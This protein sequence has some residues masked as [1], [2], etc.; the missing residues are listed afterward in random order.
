M[1]FNA[2]WASFNI[3]KKQNLRKDF[4]S[5]LLLFAYASVILN[6]LSHFKD[7][8]SFTM[9]FLLIVSI[10]FKPFLLRPGWLHG[11]LTFSG[12]QPHE[13]IGF[14]AGLGQQ[15]IMLSLV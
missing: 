7:L 8:I 14:S 13:H 5:Q 9:H 3:C 2:I 15:L 12:N 6:I 11:Y 10:N 4:F 1:Q